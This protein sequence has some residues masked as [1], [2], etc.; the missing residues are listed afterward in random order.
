MVAEAGSR[1]GWGRAGDRLA[2]TSWERTEDSWELG[3]EDSWDRKHKTAGDRKHMTVY[4]RNSV[5]QK[6][7]TK[8]TVYKRN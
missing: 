4:E 6:Q 3:T 8:E 7:F 1:G 2:L 5:Q